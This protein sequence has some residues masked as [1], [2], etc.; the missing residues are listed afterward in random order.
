MDAKHWKVIRLWITGFMSCLGLTLLGWISCVVIK[1]TGHGGWAIFLVIA[2][3]FIGCAQVADKTR[4]EV[5][6]I[7]R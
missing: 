4:Q 5:E 3:C 1:A 7:E 6:S 2:A